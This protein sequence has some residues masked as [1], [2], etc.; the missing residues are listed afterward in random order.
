MKNTAAAMNMREITEANVPP[1][2]SNNQFE[3]AVCK[4]CDAWRF[5][6]EPKGHCCG[7]GRVKLEKPKLPEELQK[8]FEKQQF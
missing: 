2:V 3:M 6:N 7:N 4:H 1:W 8:L 5:P